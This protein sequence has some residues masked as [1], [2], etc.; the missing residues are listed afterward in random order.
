MQTKT[1]KQGNSLILTVPKE[2]NIVPGQKVMPELKANGIFYRFVD[3][4]DDFLDFSTDILKF[5][6][7]QGLTGSELVSEFDRQKRAISES[8]GS[9]ADDDDTLALSRKKL[10]KRIGL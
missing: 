6:V 10:E 8:L 9:L 3:G 4:G 2:F 1:R 5:L 7:A